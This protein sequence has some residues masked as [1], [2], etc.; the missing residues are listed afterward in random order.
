MKVRQAM[1]SDVSFCLP[2]STLTEAVTIMWQRDCGV[3]PVVDMKKRVV[4]MITD[5]DI[6]IAL[7]TKHQLSNDIKVSEIIGKRVRTCTPHDDVQDALKTMK[8]W[9]L[10]RLPVV[11][12][13]EE[14]VG[15]LSI[16]DL[17][18]YAGKGKVSRKKLLSA[19]QEISSFRPL[20]L[21]ELTE[22]E[23][24]TDLPG[25]NDFPAQAD[26]AESNESE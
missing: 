25:E 9:Q 6:C 16:G 14:L 24:E 23:I 4:G 22:D 10:R 13:A 11:N 20:H 8:K 1:T 19:L 5:R 18:H 17:L 3:V 7:A 2:E 12:E 21:Q 26:R 15:I